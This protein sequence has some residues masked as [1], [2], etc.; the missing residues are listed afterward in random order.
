MAAKD[1]LGRTGE[2]LAAGY[3]EAR[4]YHI[5]ARNWRCH[6]GEIDLVAEHLGTLVVVEVKTRRSTAYGHPFD[7]ITVTKMAR[8][9]RLANAWCAESRALGRLIR[10][11]A[12]A[13]L[14]PAG[15]PAVI[16]H[17]ERISR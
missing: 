17:L 9:R 7:A 8:L 16:E 14:A 6:E 1:E 5:L 13:V 3:L 12:I 2:R 10:I 15:A 4:G 11:D